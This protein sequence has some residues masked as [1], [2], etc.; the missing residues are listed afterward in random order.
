MTTT[1]SQTVFS[2]WLTPVRLASTSNV[3]GTYNNGPSNN[4]VGAT[5]TVA[6][7]SLTIDSVVCE[8][9]DRVLLQSQTDTYTQG[10]YVVREI[11]STVILQ[12]AED[13]Q[14]IEQI[15]AGE[16]LAVGAGAVAAGNFFTV[17][18]PLPQ[19]LGVDAITYAATPSSGGAVTFLGGASTANAL[20]VFAN[21]A[22]DIK[23]AS[24]A[25]TLGQSLSITGSLTASTS[26]TATGGDIQSGSS[27]D[28]GSFI[29][30][31][32]TAANGTL[33]LAA[34]NAG[35]AFNTT[36]S[37]GTMGQ[38]TV[39]TIPDVAAATGQFL[40]K[41]AAFVNG[42]LVQASGTAGVCVDSGVAT[43]ALQ[44]KAQV[45]A[46]TTANIGGAGA[47]PISVVVAGLT[48]ASVVVATVEA[49]SN[50]VSVIACTAT[51]TGFDVTFSAD[52]GATCTLNY[53]AYI[54]AQ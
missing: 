50:P 24:T 23:A 45:K 6:A 12:R 20:A 38:S 36:I 39:Y 27:G 29:S 2:P 42:N 47:G 43:S 34:V 11:G 41:T 51:G 5:L 17:I 26:I 19:F 33:V 8:V 35:G 7:S 44:L 40:A 30:Y 49:S 25:C 9:G 31:P 3:A 14:C 48:A 52:P 15:K 4:G 22:G 54:A 18:E 21:T 32:G 10:I 13:Q 28:A 37:N 16:Y 53:V 1:F 46:A